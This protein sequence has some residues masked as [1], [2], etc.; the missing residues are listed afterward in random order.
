MNQGFNKKLS[1]FIVYL[2]NKLWLTLAILIILSAVLLVLLQLTFHHINNYK[3]EIESW[4]EQE[5]SVE[6]DIEQ[7]NIRWQQN[8]PSLSATNFQMQSDDGQLDLISVKN[9]SIEI[10]WLKS[11]VSRSVVTQSILI[12]GASLGIILDRKLGFRLQTNTSMLS[13]QQGANIEDA[14]QVL[15]NALFAQKY[16]TLTNSTLELK[17]L[18][19]KSFNYR[20]D[21]FFIRN[22]DDVHQLTGDLFDEFNAR[23]KVAAEI[24]GDP[25][26]K[27]SETSLYLE[28][29]GIDLSKL[30]FFENQVHLKP[31]TGEM[32]WKLWGDWKNKR[33]YQAVGKIELGELTWNNEKG[34]KTTDLKS[35]SS[36]FSWHF[37]KEKSGVFS[38]NNIEFNNK[39]E[40]ANTDADIFLLYSE[41][42]N[43]SLNWDIAIY[44]FQL[45]PLAEYIDL[46]VNQKGEYR[47]FFERA[48]FDV[49]VD[50]LGVRLSKQNGVWHL[51]KIH[52]QFSD[53]KMTQLGSLPSLQGLSGELSFIYGFGSLALS[54]KDIEFNTNQLFREAINIKEI[55]TS[56]NWYSGSRKPFWFEV[57]SLYAKTPDFS[58]NAKSF[59]TIN[60]DAPDLSLYAE[61]KEFNLSKKS[62]YLPTRIMG[63]LLTSHLDD[64][65]KE[66]YLPLAKFVLR[67]PVKQFPFK[68]KQ[69]V[70]AVLGHVK[71]ASYQYLSDWP[72]ADSLDARLYFEG[73]R[74]NLTATSAVLS[75]NQVTYAN[76]AI[77]D[78]SKPEAPLLLS[79]NIKSQDN[80]ARNFLLD[81]SLKSLAASLEEI[82]LLGDYKT[83]L[84]LS[85]AL[86]SSNDHKVKGS[87]K[88]NENQIDVS[89]MTFTGLDGTVMFTEN[90]VKKSPVSANYYGKPVRSEIEHLQQ[91]G[92]KDFV[93]RS[94]G[95]INSQA[96]TDFVGDSWTQ[97]VS[98]SSSFES[99]INI[100]TIDG[101][102]HTLVNIYSDLKGFGVELPSGLSK[103]KQEI[104]P[105]Q[106]NMKLGDSSTAY[107][108]W[109]QLKGKWRWFEEKKEQVKTQENKKIIR[110]N[111]GVF[112]YNTD[113][114]L[115]ESMPSHFLVNAKLKQVNLNEWLDVYDKVEADTEKETQ[116]IFPV[117]N[118]D[119][120]IEHLETNLIDLDKINL[121]FHRNEQLNW[122][123]GF[124]HTDLN[125]LM[126]MKN[127]KPWELN[128]ERAHLTP[129][130]QK[131]YK[132][133]IQRLIQK[134][135]AVS[136]S[137]WDKVSFWPEANIYCDDCQFYERNFGKISAK[138]RKTNKD[139]NLNG[140]MDKNKHHKLEFDLNWTQK[141]IEESLAASKVGQ[142]NQS[143]SIASQLSSL[144]FELKTDNLGN[145]MDEW[146]F[147]MG[148]KGTKGTINGEL[149]WENNPWNIDAVL[150]KGKANLKLGKGYL[151]QISDA[152][153]RL[154]SLLNLQSLSRRLSLDFKDV[155]KKGFFYDKITGDVQ[156]AESKLVTNNTLVDGNAAKIELSGEIDLK[157][158]TIEQKAVVTE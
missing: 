38:L 56:L 142:I 141:I 148:I 133:R 130:A 92:R 18:S 49:I 154:F 46:L 16:L 143:T 42:E 22:Y 5:Y 50:D 3:A 156:L 19:G 52:S 55:E 120:D 53:L 152:K 138:L 48:N 10:D 74:M 157:Q 158:E 131:T 7:V 123:I 37:E 134:K 125:G 9:F 82:D 103:Q 102:T 51:P 112:Y 54:G 128:F 135:S 1:Q 8:G 33:W 84:D 47:Q 60:N 79:L 91:D 116:S 24:Y 119:L 57:E 122:I 86:N 43:A 14:S 117:T 132:S 113:K 89:G 100:Q 127:D 71:E 106:L 41:L 73:N 21:E 105:I 77:N 153:V 93:I 70:F 63:P 97:F 144:N 44:N 69:G 83:Q 87:V 129:K 30:P 35:F 64:G 67:G 108:D 121:A 62:R 114:P 80:S 110:I 137:A 39:D 107:I 99:K 13:N 15:I 29:K 6:V 25:S 78:F 20:V 11:I 34:E 151:D 81:T 31:Q 61:L 139:I 26:S 96:L 136:D 118:I 147:S 104:K 155:Y 90:G 115:P 145:L 66:G 101:K 126:V 12:D 27:N 75:E 94:E 109:Q 23:L 88:F 95:M 68:Q 59:F 85:V 45:K 111:G 146:R 4:I 36:D 76:A 58:L 124:N 65:I 150:A 40:I 28:G 140:F 32:N 98:G 17:T 149:E 2:V 72:Q